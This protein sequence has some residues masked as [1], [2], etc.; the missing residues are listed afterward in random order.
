MDLDTFTITEKCVRPCLVL[1]FL[2]SSTGTVLTLRRISR[3]KEKWNKVRYTCTINKAGQGVAERCHKQ[4][5][6]RL[7]KEKMG[8]GHF[9]RAE[10]MLAV[11][12]KTH[13]RRR[14]PVGDHGEWGSV[15]VPAHTRRVHAECH[16]PMTRLLNQAPAQTRFQLQLP[17]QARPSYEN[18]DPYPPHQIRSGEA[19]HP[20]LHPNPSSLL[21]PHAPW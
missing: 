18:T 1:C 13:T 16:T 9:T 21:L 3:M 12:A 10:H 15:P 6:E 11:A 20:Y 17:R 14:L 8:G 5:R 7:D 19:T 2:L 4:K